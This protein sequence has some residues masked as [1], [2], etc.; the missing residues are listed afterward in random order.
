MRYDFK[1]DFCSSGVLGYPE[2]AV[3]DLLGFDDGDWFWFLLVRLLHM[4]FTI[5]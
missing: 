3:M 5:W 2:V 4:P 1:S